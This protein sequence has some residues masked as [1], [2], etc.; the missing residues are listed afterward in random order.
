MSTCLLLTGTNLVGP[1][2]SDGNKTILVLI[3]R[4]SHNKLAFLE[5]LLDPDDYDGNLL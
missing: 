5:R 4:V 3:Y 1:I 2:R